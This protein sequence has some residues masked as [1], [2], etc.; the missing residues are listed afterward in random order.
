MTLSAVGVRDSTHCNGR[1][2]HWT[3]FGVRQNLGISGPPQTSSR[4]LIA[5]V[6]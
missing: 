4:G 6:F 2:S 5:L 1:S 3:T